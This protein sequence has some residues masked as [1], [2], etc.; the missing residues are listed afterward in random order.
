MMLK[1]ISKKKFKNKA[2]D[3]SQLKQLGEKMCLAVIINAKQAK[4]LNKIFFSTLILMKQKNFN[5]CKIILG[6]KVTFSCEMHHVSVFAWSWVL[7][8]LKAHLH[9]RSH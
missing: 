9:G 3:E 6:R 4:N 8:W 2:M 1:Q 5:S 7:K